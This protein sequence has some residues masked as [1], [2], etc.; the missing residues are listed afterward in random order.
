MLKFNTILVIFFLYRFVRVRFFCIKQIFCTNFSIHFFHS[1]KYFNQDTVFVI[2]AILL[3]SEKYEYIAI[4]RD[5]CFCIIVVTIDQYRMDGSIV[6]QLGIFT[7]PF[8]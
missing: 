3:Y 2:P 5:F 4:P 6:F 7:T 1:N 8:H